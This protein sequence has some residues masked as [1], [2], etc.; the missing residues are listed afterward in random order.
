MAR[1]LVIEDHADFRDTLTAML[2]SADHEVESGGNGREALELL[3]EASF[4]LLVM[5]VLMPEIDG[6][7]VLRALEKA[8]CRMPVVAISGG[9]LL[10]ASLA[11][12][13]A[14]AL[15]ASAVLYKPFLRQELIAAV[16]R[17][18]VPGRTLH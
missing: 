12:S 1:I 15:G 11:L 6:I 5:D 9:G 4:D 14:T 2:R 13:L 8:P 16:D 10:P 3:A 17:V 18:L 7:E